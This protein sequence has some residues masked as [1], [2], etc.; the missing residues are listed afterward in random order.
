MPSKIIFLIKDYLFSIQAK[1]IFFTSLVVI[2]IMSL[3]GYQTIR[4]ERNILLE[5]IQAEGVILAE[6]M[7]IPFVTALLYEEVGLVEEAG[8]LDHVPHLLQTELVFL[9]EL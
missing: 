8:L 7:A 6:S 5:H 3:I 2:I 1:L 4:K 9:L